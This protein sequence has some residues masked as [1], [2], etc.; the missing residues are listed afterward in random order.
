MITKEEARKWYL[1]G[2]EDFMIDDNAEHFTK[3]DVRNHF[4]A[5]YGERFDTSK[6]SSKLLHPLM[7]YFTYAHLP[8]HLQE[9]SQPMAELVIAM[10]LKLPMNIETD[11]FV[12]KMLEAKDCAVRA[13]LYKGEAEQ[14]TGQ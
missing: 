1:Q 3:D 10:L 12:R 6:E 4:D 7:Q 9:I 13:K 8:A 11:A 5:F 2:A 14:T